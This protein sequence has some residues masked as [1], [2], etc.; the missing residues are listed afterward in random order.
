MADPTPH[1][2]VTP[3]S[4]LKIRAAIGAGWF[5]WVAALSAINSAIALSGEARDCVPRIS[6]LPVR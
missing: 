1:P 6:G 2:A 5:Y 3:P 4:P